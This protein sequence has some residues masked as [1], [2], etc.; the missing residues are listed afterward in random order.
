MKLREIR[1]DVYDKIVAK[2]KILDGRTA[3]IKVKMLE[4][5][6]QDKEK[7]FK[8][9]EE[10]LLKREQMLQEQINLLQSKLDNV[11]AT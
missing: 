4:L 2:E 1:E 5:R 3:K 11:N 7:Q 8:M 6:L 9:K 10:G